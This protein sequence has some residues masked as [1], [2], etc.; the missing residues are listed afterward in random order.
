M[1]EYKKY[2]KSLTLKDSTIKNYIW[3]VDKF[4]KWLDNQKISKSIVNEYFD[5]LLKKYNSVNTINLRLKIIN[6]YLK[7]NNQPEHFNLLSN[8]DTN[9]QILTDSELAE[10]LDKASKKSN[11]ISIRDKALLELLYYSGLKVGQI[12]QLKINQIDYKKRNNTK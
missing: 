11:L 10:F 6:N 12:I 7:F 5:Y 4:L 2:L 1:Q 8:E 9:I 3:H